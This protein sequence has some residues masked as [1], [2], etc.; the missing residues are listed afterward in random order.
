MT[1]EC[2]THGSLPYQPRAVSARC[3]ECG[4]WWK[5]DGKRENDPYD[6]AKM[7]RRTRRKRTARKEDSADSLT[8]T[9]ENGFSRRGAYKSRPGTRLPRPIRRRSQSL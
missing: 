4:Q 6:I 2:N 5:P 8:C 7:L 1:I 9:S 3:Q